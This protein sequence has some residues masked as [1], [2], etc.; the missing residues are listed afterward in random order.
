M[1]LSPE[2]RTALTVVAVVIL[3][4]FTLGLGLAAGF[5]IG[6]TLAAL[7]VVVPLVLALT[8]WLRRRVSA[9]KQGGERDGQ[10]R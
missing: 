4:A 2:R 10:E 9:A 8:Y 5:A 6:L 3:A 7:V 1:S